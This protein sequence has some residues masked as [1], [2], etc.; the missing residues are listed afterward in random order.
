MSN[1]ATMDSDIKMEEPAAPS[2][3][4]ATASPASSAPAATPNELVKTK[5]YR[6]WKKKY[7]KMRIAFD[8]NMEANEVLHKQEVVA[9]HTTKRLAVEIDRI[10]D[11]LLDINNT[12][13][14]PA[15]KRIDLGLARK[16]F[17]SL[18]IDS[19]GGWERR[20]LDKSNPNTTGLEAPTKSLRDLVKEVPHMD[21]S[22]ASKHHPELL[23][24][25]VPSDSNARAFAPPDD[26]S[27][28]QPWNQTPVPTPSHSK[29]KAVEKKNYPESFLTADDVDNYLWEVDRNVAARAL[30]AGAQAPPM[31]P[32]LAPFANLPDMKVSA[33]AKNDSGW[34]EFFNRS[35]TKADLPSIMT[36]SSATT[37]R[38]GILHNPTSVY[39]WLREHAPKSIFLQEGEAT[40]AAQAAAAAAAAAAAEKEGAASDSYHHYSHGANGNGA[41][42]TSGSAS[43]RKR[44]SA[45]A[46]KPIK[47][48]KVDK[49]DK[50][51]RGGRA[52]GA[53]ASPVGGAAPRGSKR[54]S[55]AAGGSSLARELIPPHDDADS[56]D[57]SVGPSTPRN[58]TTSAAANR[59]GKRK[60]T[61]DDEAGYRSKAGNNGTPASGAGPS[62][63]SRATKRKR[64]SEGG[65]KDEDPESAA[66]TPVMSKKRQRRSDAAAAAAD[67]ENEGASE[68]AVDVDADA[69]VGDEDGGDAASPADR[70]DEDGI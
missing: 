54:P 61:A 48:E 30:L 46:D 19:P 67:A 33:T 47:A 44:K 29:E 2:L 10:L 24:D 59:G 70:G 15:T 3:E 22:T 51:A 65:G 37:T 38:D 60:R 69:T 21:L 39:N 34:D 41:G 36:S 45:A 68:A 49:A 66:A 18:D 5:P 40:A 26:Y 58:G 9:L 43:A 35:I 20:Y 64:K 11:L 6:S 12:P 55:M 63:A 16:E 53:S 13:Q 27:V 31:V 25:L 4:H 42:A 28:P 32:T 57:V 50:P 52:S 14:I 56:D 7:Q 1:L 62:S 17:G 8:D 23:R